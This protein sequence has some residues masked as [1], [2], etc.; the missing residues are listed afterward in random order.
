[1]NDTH[2][3][4]AAATGDSPVA[5]L[6]AG[7]TFIAL[8]A[9]F[10]FGS[11]RYDIGSALRMGTGYVP[12][13]L[14]ATL[15]AL[16][17]AIVVQGVVARARSGSG[18]PAP[19]EPAPDEPADHERGPVPWFRG[20]LLIASVVVFG[21]TVQGLG[22]AVSLFV[23]TYLAAIAGH[24]NGPLKAAVVAAGLTVLSLV[25]FVGLL[26]LRLPI[27]GEWLGG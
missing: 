24:R 17:L 27:R 5:D 3:D 6:L 25:I 26:Q 19:G 10:A 23:T 12:L 2:A 4:G 1:M 18:E 8:G 9:G 22:L 21:L 13:V 11:L 7:A 16:G 15:A 14:G 20:A